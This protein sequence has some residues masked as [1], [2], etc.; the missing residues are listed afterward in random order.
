MK[1][2]IEWLKENNRVKK[3]YF[4]MLTSILTLLFTFG[5]ALGFEIKDKQNLG[6]FD[7]GDIGSTMLGGL[8]GQIIIILLFIIW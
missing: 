8:I 2:L 6:I 3:F 1:N 4:G 7:W 5:I